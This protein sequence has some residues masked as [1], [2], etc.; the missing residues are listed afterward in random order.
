VT[1]SSPVYRS[2]NLINLGSSEVFSLP[3]NASC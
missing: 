2:F 3:I 1:D